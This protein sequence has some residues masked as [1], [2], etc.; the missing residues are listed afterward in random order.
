LCSTE[1]PIDEFSIYRLVN[2]SARRFQCKRCI[3]DRELERRQ[4]TGD[5]KRYS[6]EHRERVGPDVLGESRRAAY[7]ANPKPSIEATTRWRLNNLEKDGERQRLWR[8]KNPTYQSAW[9]Q[10]N[11]VK[12]DAKSREWE[13]IHPAKIRQYSLLSGHKRRAEKAQSGG[14]FTGQQWLEVI[15]KFDERCVCCGDKKPLTADHVVP[16]SRGGSSFIENIQP[17]C[18]SCN[19]S[20]GNHHS[21]DYRK[22]PFSRMGQSILFA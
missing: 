18:K 15:K 21:T 2:G 5:G 1:K 9:Y 14:S 4:R 7:K 6:R 13:A 22:F 20:K 12:R 3:Q 11:K 8:E 17:L 19:S 16:L 10:K